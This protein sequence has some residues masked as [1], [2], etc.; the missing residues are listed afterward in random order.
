MKYIT[1]KKNDALTV[2][3]AS[4]F[5]T[6]I[7]VLAGTSAIYAFLLL[8]ILLVS[9]FTVLVLGKTT[10]LAIVY[11]LF[12]FKTIWLSALIKPLFL[13]S[14][15]EGLFTPL[16]TMSVYFLGML[17]G[18]FAAFLI[19]FYQP[20]R[21]LLPIDDMP[22]SFLRIFSICL[23]VISLGGWFLLRTFTDADEVA[24][25]GLWGAVKA[26]VP[27]G[28]VGLALFAYVQDKN[29]YQSKRDFFYFVIFVVLFFLE[30]VVGAGKE[31]MMLPLIIVFAVMVR[32]N[33]LFSVKVLVPSLVGILFFT[34]V[35]YPY[36]QYARTTALRVSSFV[37]AV[38]LAAEISIRTIT[39]ASFRDRLNNFN[40]VEWTF[41]VYAPD[42]LSAISR[43]MF[44][45]E[46]DYLISQTYSKQVFTGLTTITPGF[47][48]LVPH[49]LYPNKPQHNTG[50]F[51][52]YY[53]NQLSE[54]DY[55]TQ[56]SYGFF[57]NLYHAFGIV[58]VLPAT[59]LLVL[60]IF[61]CVTFYWGR[62]KHFS[63]SII[64]I[65]MLMQ[66]S[67]TEQS[68]AGQIQV[69]RQPIT[70]AILFIAIWLVMSVLNRKIRI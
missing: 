53:A 44:I 46:S 21:G 28:I 18:L 32:I 49:F 63:P 41:S 1:I 31:Q 70:F 7:N 36:A 30:G 4:V 22:L 57:A 23:C 51:L 47:E 66:H 17:G 56:V 9:G 68:V 55:S 35:I 67:F 12:S 20:K 58:W 13:E 43:L 39:D 50:A 2:L 38:E 59:F 52:G 64:I 27:L 11:G 15:E 34:V 3:Y 10:G 54:G 37:D 60:F 8:G 24:V 19:G 61:A 42:S 5:L 16:I 48:L 40:P 6:F 26:F 33:G 62:P 65:V 45:G 25:G 14:F 69:I 29:K